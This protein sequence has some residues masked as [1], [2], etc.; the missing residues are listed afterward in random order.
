MSRGPTLFY[1]ALTSPKAV[2]EYE[3]IFK[4]PKTKSN[5]HKTKTIKEETSTSSVTGKPKAK[6]TNAKKRSS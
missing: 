6:N 2:A 4:K 1:H 5:D 3:R